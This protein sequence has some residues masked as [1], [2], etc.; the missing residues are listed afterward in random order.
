MKYLG[1]NTNEKECETFIKENC[2]VERTPIDSSSI[3]IVIYIKETKEEIACI[4]GFLYDYKTKCCYD[5]TK[6]ALHICSL[7][8]QKNFLKRGF[9]T[10]LI[11]EVIKYGEIRKVKHITIYPMASTV[12]ISQAALKTF[13]RKFLFTYRVLFIKQEKKLEFDN[14]PT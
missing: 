1:E 5:K 7:G 6:N 3:K 9:A 10:Y 4:E 13:Y 11:K 14:I 2:V 8:T 12:T